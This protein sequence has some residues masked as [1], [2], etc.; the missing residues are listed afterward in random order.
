[1]N[2]PQPG[3][4]PSANSFIKRLERWATELNAL[5]T[6][7]AVGLAILDVTCYAALSWTPPRAMSHVATAGAT[8]PYV[9]SGTQG[10]AGY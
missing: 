7:L 5:L 1:M 9:G 3:N 10:M 2:N 6:I 8:V 4:R